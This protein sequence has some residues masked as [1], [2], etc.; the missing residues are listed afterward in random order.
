VTG[1]GT[2]QAIIYVTDSSTGANFISAQAPFNNPGYPNV[3][4]VIGVVKLESG[5]SL[6]LSAETSLAPGATLNGYDVNVVIEQLQ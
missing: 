4:G 3:G 6:A 2:I 1:S 5:I